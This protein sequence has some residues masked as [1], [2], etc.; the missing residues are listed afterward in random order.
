ML[1]RMQV[2]LPGLLGAVLCAG[3][4]GGHLSVQYNGHRAHRTHYVDTAH[5]CT[6]HCQDHYY[7]GSRVVVIREHRHGSGCGH[8]WDGGHWVANR[9][10]PGPTP[11]VHVCRRD[12]HHHYYDGDRLIVGAPWDEY[13]FDKSGAAYIFD[14][15]ERTDDTGQRL[16]PNDSKVRNFGQAVDIRSDTVAISAITSVGESDAHTTYVFERTS[17]SKI[18]T[19][20]PDQR[21]LQAAASKISILHS[22]SLSVIRHLS[23]VIEIKAVAWQM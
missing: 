2:I 9:H 16:V 21:Y 17:S 4:H 3:C 12:C 20:Y 7:D 6:R 13:E 11:V 8:R 5:V 10:V 1:N 22:R 19:T 15:D 18:V 23:F 14:L